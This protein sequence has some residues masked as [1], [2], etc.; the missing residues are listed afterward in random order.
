[1]A[2]HD[3]V[4]RSTRAPLTSASPRPEQRSTSCTSSAHRLGPDG[5]AALSPADTCPDNNVLTADGLLLLDFEGAEWRHVAWDIAYL[6][7]PWPTCWC[8]WRL[9]DDVA[10]AALG[11]Y[12]AAAGARVRRG[13]RRRHRR[14]R[15]RLGVHLGGP[16]PG[17]ALADDPPRPGTGRRPNR[18]AMILH[19]LGG[20]AAKPELP[21][22]ADLAA[23]CAPNWSAAG[24]R[25]SW[26][27][28]RRSRD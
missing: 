25:S 26:P 18:R 27:T 6:R 7:V 5:A 4:A 8:S 3:A 17:P 23:G 11:R 16:V 15:T 10:V 2:L 13:R 9:A 22:A 19:R 21:R 24:A 12:R 14:R 28:R 1:M 20:A